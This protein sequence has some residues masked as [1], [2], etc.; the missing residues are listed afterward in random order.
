MSGEAFDSA[1]IERME[2]TI[3]ME[4]SFMYAVQKLRRE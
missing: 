3:E 4:S 1:G 2:V